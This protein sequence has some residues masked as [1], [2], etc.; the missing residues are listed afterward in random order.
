MKTELALRASNAAPVAF[1]AINE[2]TWPPAYLKVAMRIIRLHPYTLEIQYVEI[3]AELVRGSGVPKIKI[4]DPETKKQAQFPAWILHSWWP[5]KAE[6]HPTRV[7][8][9]MAMEGGLNSKGLLLQSIDW[10]KGAHHKAGLHDREKVADLRFNIQ[11][12]AEIFATSR[13]VSMIH[14][15]R[16]STPE[17]FMKLKLR[18]EIERA[19]IQA[20]TP[21]S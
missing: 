1:D 8:L 2:S 3:V 18:S 4:R 19:S 17:D 11:L 12:D 10:I 13:E 20:S 16:P 14:V 7:R 5:E 15:E 9:K 6:P 21:P